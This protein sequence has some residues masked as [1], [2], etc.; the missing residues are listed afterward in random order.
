MHAT[1]CRVHGATADD[2]NV[3]AEESKGRAGASRAWFEVRQGSPQLKWVERGEEVAAR[4]REA[5]LCGGAR[6]GGPAGGEEV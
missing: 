1:Q 6:R 2:G 4:R 3:A 5:T